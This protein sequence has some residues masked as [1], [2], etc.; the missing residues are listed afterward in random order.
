MDV[1]L[2]PASFNLATASKRSPESKRL[3]QVC[4]GVLLRGTLAM[5][6]TGRIEIEALIVV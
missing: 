1:F 3:E 2:E 4:L 5:L 6:V